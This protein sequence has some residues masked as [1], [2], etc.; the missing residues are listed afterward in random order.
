MQLLRKS[1]LSGPGRGAAG[2][3]WK[4]IIF[5]ENPLFIGFCKT[6]GCRKNLKHS[7]NILNS[8]LISFKKLKL[9][10]IALLFE[11]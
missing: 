11:R 1:S 5:I 8:I 7:V 4:N 2:L 9:T 10:I 3:L 6:C